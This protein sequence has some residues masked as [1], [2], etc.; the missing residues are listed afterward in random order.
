MQAEKEICRAL[1][2]K[3]CQVPHSHN[4]NCAIQFKFHT[5]HCFIA[6]LN[7]PLFRHGTLPKMD[8]VARGKYWKVILDSFLAT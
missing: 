1:R 3:D 8:S 2:L 6:S 5:T 4:C 7:W